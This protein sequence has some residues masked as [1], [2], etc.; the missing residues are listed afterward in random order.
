MVRVVGTRAR[1]PKVINGFFS[2]GTDS[3]KLSVGNFS[4]ILFL[5]HSFGKYHIYNILGSSL[6][7][8]WNFRVFLG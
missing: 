8:L 3:E 7:I 5:N 6:A 2:D 1:E 4:C